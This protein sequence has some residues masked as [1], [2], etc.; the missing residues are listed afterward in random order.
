MAKRSPKAVLPGE[1]Y[2]KNGRWWWKVRLPG[3]ARV[4]ARALKPDGA[5]VAPKTRKVAEEVACERWRLSIE[6][7]TEA[8]VKSEIQ[9]KAEKAVAQA[10]AEAA[11]AIAKV[12]AECHEQLEAGAQ[13]LA[14]AQEKARAEAAKRASVEAKLSAQS[15][16]AET[17]GA[18]E[19]TEQ[20]GAQFEQREKAYRDALNEARQKVQAEATLRAEAE[21]RAQMEARARAIAEARAQAEAELRSEAE[22]RANLQAKAGMRAETKFRGQT[23]ST[24]RTGPCEGCGQQDVP[25][26][27]LAKIDSGQLVCPDCL[28]LIRA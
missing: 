28:M 10:K 15:E 1:M 24:G 27:D 19:P 11:D 8:R 13:A 4:R 2:Q 16:Q 14:K 3:E 5:R 25:E 6:A 20:V 26:E 7:E 17:L 21:Q 12:E 22:Q 9:A 18:G 23:E